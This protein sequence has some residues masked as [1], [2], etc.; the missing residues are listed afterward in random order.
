M[1]DPNVTPNTPSDWQ[2]FQL[3]DRHVNLVSLKELLIRLFDRTQPE[4][5]QIYV[6][7]TRRS[8][9]DTALS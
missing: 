3:K 8:G 7:L 9:R 1:N 6:C 2:R 5:F 4:D